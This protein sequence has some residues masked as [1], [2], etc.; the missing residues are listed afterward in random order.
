M[1]K[2]CLEKQQNNNNNNKKYL[3]KRTIVSKYH[4]MSHPTGQWWCMPLLIPILGS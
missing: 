3:K 4:V 2:P 1:E